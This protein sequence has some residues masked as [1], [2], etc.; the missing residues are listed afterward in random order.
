MLASGPG[1]PMVIDV[2]P[3]GAAQSERGLADAMLTGFGLPDFRL[4]AER[5]AHDPPEAR[6]VAR[7]PLRG[8]GM[9][10][11][12]TVATPARRSVASAA[13]RLEAAIVGPRT[14]ER[15]RGCPWATRWRHHPAACI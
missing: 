1:D 5:E 7:V 12:G 8:Q 9:G 15:L 4:P 6:G 11:E 14:A 10:E 2:T 13:P 3:P